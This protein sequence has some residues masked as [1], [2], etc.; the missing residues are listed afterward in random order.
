[1]NIKKILTEDLE[2][3]LERRKREIPRM[4]D[5]FSFIVLEKLC[6]TYIEELA[7]N[8][9]VDEDYEHYIFEEAMKSFYND[10]VFDWI[11]KIQK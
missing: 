7:V 5:N 11:N 6:K 4:C 1:M 9:Y 8:G 3:E 10:N 2:K